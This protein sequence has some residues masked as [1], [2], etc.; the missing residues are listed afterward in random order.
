MPRSKGPEKRGVK[1][2]L[3][4]P[5]IAWL[6]RKAGDKPVPTYL[7]ERLE[8][9]ADNMAK[10]AVSGSRQRDAVEP[11]FKGKNK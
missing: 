2:W 10:T 11:R 9:E 3:T 8:Q 4:L 6:E 1:L 7:A 5:T